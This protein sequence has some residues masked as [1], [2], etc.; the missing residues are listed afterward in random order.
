MHRRPL[1]S[2]LLALAAVCSTA[3]CATRVTGT[4]SAGE[5]PGS[6]AAPE[7]SAS[8][9]SAPKPE[10]TTRCSYG[11]DRGDVPKQVEPPAEDEAPASGD[12]RF[13]V[14]TDQGEL[15]F[16]FDA[17]SA[18]CSVHSFRSLVEQSYYDGAAC[19]RVTVSGIF[20]LQCGDPGGTGTGG[21]GYAFDDPEAVPGTY[22]RG[23]VAM[24]NAGAGTNGSQFFIVHRDSEIAPDYP[25]MGRVT[26]G[27][28]VV[29]RVA[30]AGV[31]P[32]SGRGEGDG[33][34][35]L[36]ITLTSVEEG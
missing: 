4:P 35:L 27:L 9:S 33:R 14:K 10:K 7:S 19:H 13:A 8:K 24:A 22:E 6:S 16:E 1:V 3:S 32:G 26:R 2:A 18:P 12:V 28:E 20:V 29:D 31:V 25:I 15:E 17:A 23:V 11:P 5:A 36:P 21:P 34:P 30:E